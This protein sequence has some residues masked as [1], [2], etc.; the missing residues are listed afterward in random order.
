MRIDDPS[1]NAGRGWRRFEADEV[2]SLA[3]L[4]IRL[5]RKSLRTDLSGR[6]AAKAD[7]AAKL[8]AEA[9]SNRLQAYPVFGPARAAGSHSTVGQP[10]PYDRNGE[11]AGQ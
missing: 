6:D 5:T 9:V 3:Y 7:A 8:L 2:A 4:A 10:D 1:D 11:A